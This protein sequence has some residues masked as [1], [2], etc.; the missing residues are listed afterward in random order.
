MNHVIIPINPGFDIPD[1]IWQIGLGLLIL[2]MLIICRVAYK[3]DVDEKP[4]SMGG[5]GAL[6]C[7]IGFTM[8]VIPCLNWISHGQHNTPDLE[9]VAKHFNLRILPGSDSNVVDADKMFIDKNDVRYSECY[10]TTTKIDKSHVSATL[11]CLRDDKS[12][13]VTK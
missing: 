7:V 6:A 10:A 9:T 3:T 4:S 2:G 5:I 1:L 8:T 12:V 13:L 11:H